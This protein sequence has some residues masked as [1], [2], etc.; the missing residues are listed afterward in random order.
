MV[1]TNMKYDNQEVIRGRIHNVIYYTGVK[2]CICLLFVECDT[3][4]SG[5]T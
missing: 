4:V 5:E 2:E 3:T 1:I